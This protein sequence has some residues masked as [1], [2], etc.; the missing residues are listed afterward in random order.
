MLHPV[1]PG[2]GAHPASFLYVKSWAVAKSAPFQKETARFIKYLETGANK[3]AVMKSVPVH[4]WPPLRSVAE[5][6]DFLDQPLLKT[7]AGQK[8]LK[9]LAEA[10]KSGQVPLS[11]SGVPILK[12]GPVL[13]KRV[14]AASLEQI[15]VNGANA[16]ATLEAAAKDL[17]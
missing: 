13:Q 7:P 11:E 17:N 14:L 15:V 3:I 6:P 5:N 4:Y 16:K 10:V 12:L 9:V 2:K 1:G 8:S